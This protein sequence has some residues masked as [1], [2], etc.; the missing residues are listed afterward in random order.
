MKEHKVPNPA[1]PHTPVKETEM[2]ET[3]ATFAFMC[4]DDLFAD[5]FAQIAVEFAVGIPQRFPN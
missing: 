4:Q 3:N 5:F 2:R 1:D